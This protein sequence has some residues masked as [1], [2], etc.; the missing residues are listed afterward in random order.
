MDGFQPAN[1]GYYKWMAVLG[2][3]TIFNQYDAAGIERSVDVLQG[4]SV[5]SFILIPQFQGFAPIQ[6]DVE[7][8]EAWIKCWTRTMNV[9]EIVQD[10]GTDQEVVLSARQTEAPQIEKM[11][12]RVKGGTWVY[13]YIYFNGTVRMTLESEP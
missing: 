7:G 8:G 6:F 2:D 12:I 9:A 10:I 4:Q 13:L 3:D 1:R 5:K 11:A